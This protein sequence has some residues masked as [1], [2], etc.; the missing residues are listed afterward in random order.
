MSK[1]TTA[2]PKGI[3]VVAFDFDDT[4]VGT[5]EPIWNLHR[6]IA[7][8]FYGV[9]LTDETLKKYWGQPVHTLV[10]HYY[11]TDDI[12]TAIEHLRASSV[13]FSKRTFRETVPAL[14]KLKAAGYD[15][16]LVSASYDWI[17]RDDMLHA[18]IPSDLLDYIQTAEFTTVHKPDP[19]V[20]EPMLQWTSSNS[21]LPNEILYIGDGLQDMLAAQ[22]AHLQFL[23]VTTGLVSAEEFAKQGAKTIKSLA[24]L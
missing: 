21:V 4:L 8:K 18:G 7:K 3:K 5:H 24:E 22:G 15:T 1:T 9:Q 19:L 11:Q 2:I 14:E 6:H 17:V 20:F 16:A 23:A 13:D 10:H 12:D